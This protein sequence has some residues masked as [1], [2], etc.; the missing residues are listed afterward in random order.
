MRTTAKSGDRPHRAVRSLRRGCRRGSRSLRPRAG[1]RRSRA[2]FS[3]PGR[4]ARPSRDG[5]DELRPPRR[6]RSR[7]R[8]RPSPTA[9]SVASRRSRASRR[10]SPVDVQHGRVGVDH[11][12]RPSPA[13]ERG[14]RPP[15][16]EPPST[17]RSRRRAR[18]SCPPSRRRAVAASRRAD[19]GRARRAAPIASATPATPRRARQRRAARGASRERREVERRILAQDRLLEALSSGPA[20]ARLVHEHAAR[21]GVGLERLGLPA[22]AVEREHQLRPQPLAERMAADER[23]QLADSSACG[24]AR[25]PPRARSS[26][27]SQARPAA[28]AS[29]AKARPRGL[30]AAVRARGRAPRALRR[31]RDPRPRGGR[32]PL[33]ERSNDVDRARRVDGTTYPGERVSITGAAEQLAEPRDVPLKRG[34]GVLRRRRPESVDQPVDRDDLARESRIA[35]TLRCFAPPRRG[36]VRRRGPRAARESESRGRWRGTDPTTGRLS[37]A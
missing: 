21:V 12:A 30:R 10:P 11:P 29:R 35:S 6:L 8:R 16:G 33:P 13:G 7:P 23:P 22:R 34:R 32:V 9:M 28:G 3:S 2:R 27:S 4:A 5:T 15:G 25:G 26:A 37:G 1:A 20:R 36:G 31:L 24:R 17:C 19:H 14:R 18:P